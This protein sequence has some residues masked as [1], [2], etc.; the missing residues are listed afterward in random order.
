MAIESGRSECVRLLLS[1]KAI[2]EA[3]QNSAG[4][5][6][7]IAAYFMCIM[8]TENICENTTHTKAQQWEI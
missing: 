6:F 7:I 8:A 5:F 3:A 2:N 4:L 1:H